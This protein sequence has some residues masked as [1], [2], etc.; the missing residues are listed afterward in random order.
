MQ[1]T[2]LLR[3][4]QQGLS[5]DLEKTVSESWMLVIT[6]THRDLQV[7]VAEGQ[8]GE[9]FYYRLNVLPIHMPALRGRREVLGVW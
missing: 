5:L 9:D 3:F 2:I 4:L 6:A 1:Q 8:F 7:E